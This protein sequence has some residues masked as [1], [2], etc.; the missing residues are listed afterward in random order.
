MEY[1]KEE[2]EELI[3]V[4]N[5]PYNTIG[6]TY[7]CTGSNIRKVAKKFGIEL[8]QR[9]KINESETFR[10]GVNKYADLVCVNC[11]KPLDTTTQ[12]KY[13][14]ITCQKEFQSKELYD[15]FLTSPKEYQ[16]GNY[17]ITTVKPFILK[18]QGNK[19]A[20]CG[21]DSVWNN[22]HLVL[23]LDHIDGDAANN[24]RENYRCIC[25]NCDSQLDT[26]KSKNKNSARNEFRY[27]KDK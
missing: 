12:R 6:L 10:K 4:Q 13:C 23:I 22:K 8:P 25:P 1:I 21:M 16:R 2:L 18:E 27:P 20:I 3:L 17:S 9:R 24:I 15:Y 26:F 19:C 14:G 11:G 7:G 5:I